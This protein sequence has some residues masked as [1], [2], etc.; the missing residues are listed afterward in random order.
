MGGIVAYLYAG[1][2]PNRPARLVIGDV[3][4]DIADMVRANFR[5]APSAEP[6]LFEHPEEAIKAALAATPARPEGEQRRRTLGNLLQR[7]DGRWTW[8]YDPVLA[9]N[10]PVRQ[11]PTPEQWATLARVTCPTLI[12]RGEQSPVLSRETAERM[13]QVLPVGRLVELPDY[14]HDN[15]SGNLTG[16]LAVVRPFL[17]GTA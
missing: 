9:T 10:D 14:G 13:A 4:P 3:G 5:T 16:M 11:V 15:V 6:Q 7:L 12:L 8:R 17:L 2:F 1:R